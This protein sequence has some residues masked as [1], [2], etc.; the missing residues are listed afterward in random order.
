VTAKWS[1]SEIVRDH[2]GTLRDA[3]S[4]RYRTS[5]FF[6]FYAAPIVVAVGAYFT[7]FKLQGIEAAVG[8]V[9]IYTALLFGM[10]IHVF[11]LRIRVAD[12]ETLRASI[13]LG[14]LIDELE[15]NV[16]YAVLVGIAATSALVIAA[17]LLGTTNPLPRGASSVLT[18]LFV[19]LILSTFLVLKRVRAAY[20][21]S[22]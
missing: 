10:L 6:A 4:N 16:A 13:R 8:G 12:S 2:L 3:R 19:H 14:R 22:V 1:V 9:A 11:Q 20:A 15:S 7:G 18:A 17:S 21:E 5:D